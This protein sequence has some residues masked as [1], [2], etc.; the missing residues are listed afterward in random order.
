LFLKLGNPACIY[1]GSNRN[2]YGRFAFGE[3]VMQTYK[4][5]FA[6][7]N[8]QPIGEP[9]EIDAKSVM[10]L[11]QKINKA[12]SQSKYPDSLYANYRRSSVVIPQ[13]AT[14]YQ[15]EPLWA[16]LKTETE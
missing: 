16:E 4:V 15:Y 11:K 14:Q 12:I 2:G 1:C 10:G 9:I 8:K 7:D 3:M 5:Q 13:G 6:D